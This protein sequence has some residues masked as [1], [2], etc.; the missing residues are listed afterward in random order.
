MSTNVLTL[1]LVSDPR[2]NGGSFPFWGARKGE[3]VQIEKYIIIQLYAKIYH[4][5]TINFKRT[6]FNLHGLQ[7]T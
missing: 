2:G 6:I 4:I 3:K 1:P 7:A 5:A